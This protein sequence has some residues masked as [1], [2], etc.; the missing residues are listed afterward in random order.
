MKLD[1]KQNHWVIRKTGVW[2]INIKHKPGSAGLA[3]VDWNICGVQNSQ[4]HL[5]FQGKN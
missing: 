3:F 1:Y 5:D 4:A 2:G